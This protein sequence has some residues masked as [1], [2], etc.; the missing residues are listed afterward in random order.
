ATE[1]LLQRLIWAFVFYGAVLAW[2]R[3]PSLLRAGWRTWAQL[4]L[5]G[6]LLLANWLTFIYAVNTGRVVETSLGYFM[7]PLLTA[8]LGVLVF[9]EPLRRSQRLALGL[10]AL[11]LGV[12]AWETGRLPWISLALAASYSLYGLLRK[13][14]PQDS[15]AA[16]HLETLGML[17][18]LLGGL[19]LQPGGLAPVLEYTPGTWGLLLIAGPLTGL[20][21]IWFNEG[22]T[23]LP[24]S[25]L[26]FVQYLAPTL[27]FVLGVAL[28]HE[29]LSAWRVI[30]FGFVWSAVALAVRD[31]L[32]APAA[33]Q[34]PRLI[35]RMSAQA[36]SA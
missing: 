10:A 27:Q 22:V 5:T 7:S 19:A 3:R 12:M 34:R 4:L 26:G 30:G 31:G 17:P 35:A 9:H 6:A 29:P 25:Q 2:R 28:F 24:L 21:L 8:G 18:V 36:A 16:A 32:R 15:Y 14:H 33:A 20:P 23:R 1:I 11:G 13:L